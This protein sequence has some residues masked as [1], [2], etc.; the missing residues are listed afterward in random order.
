MF[1]G[2]DPETCIAQCQDTF[3]K[4]YS[5]DQCR[6]VWENV[7]V[8][9]HKGANLILPEVQMELGDVCTED[10]KQVTMVE[11]EE[12]NLTACDLLNARS[13]KGNLLWSKQKRTQAKCDILVTVANSS[14][15][16][17]AL[18]KAT[19]HEAIFAI[20][21]GDHFTSDIMFKAD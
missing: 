2:A 17:E 19:A 14:D 9:S 3:S 6:A 5:V 15:R 16:T 13:F 1:G 11:M 10:I 21:G 20:I 8:V 12:T 7:G 18:V 4:S